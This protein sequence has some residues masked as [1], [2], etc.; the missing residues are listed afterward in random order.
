V[1][2]VKTE[3]DIDAPSDRVWDLI[4]DPH[5]FADWVSIHRKLHRADPGPPREGM[6]VDQTLCIRGANFKV[7]WRLAECD[8]RTHAAWEGRGPFGSHA[9]TV[10]DLEPD[11]G[12][13]RFHYTNEFKAPGGPLGAMASKVLVGGVPEREAE[14]SLQQ[15]KALAER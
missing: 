6:E 7:H 4:M 12:T 14:R 13:T 1:T 5:R 10:Y 11:G 9:R 3:I 2:E 15:L 8:G